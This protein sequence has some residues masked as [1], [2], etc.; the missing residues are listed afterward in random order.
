MFPSRIVPARNCCSVAL[1]GDCSGSSSV[2]PP[3]MV[4]LVLLPISI[5]TFFSMRTTALSAN[6]FS[7]AVRSAS[8]DG[9]AN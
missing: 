1:A 4:L 6:G 8:A 9:A 2:K 3:K 7:P 5:M